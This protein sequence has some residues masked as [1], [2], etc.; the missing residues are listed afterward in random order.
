MTPVEP[1]EK[2]NQKTVLSYLK[3]KGKR[4]EPIYNV[5]DL[6]RTADINKIFSQGDST[7]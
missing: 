3:D 7:Y 5:A 2:I 1:F 6:V 4:C